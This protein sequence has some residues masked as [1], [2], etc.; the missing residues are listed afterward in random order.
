M[1]APLLFRNADAPDLA[2]NFLVAAVAAVVGVRVLLYLTGYPSV[3]GARLH[4]AHMLWG[5]LLLAIALVVLLSYIGAAA[6]AIASVVGGLGFG[7]FIDEIGKFVTRDNDYFYRPAVALMYLVF[8]LLYLAFRKLHGP[9]LTPTERVANALELMQEAVRRDMDADEWRRA[10]ALLERSGAD[11]LVTA[12]RGALADVTVAPH[13]RPGPM[14]RARLRLR[15][16]YRSLVA[17]RGFRRFT[18]LFFLLQAL[19]VLLEAIVLVPAAARLVAVA[20]VALFGAYGI[21]RLDAAG[22]RHTAI[23][24]A[25]VAATALLAV[26]GLVL[27]AGGVPALS[28]F[29]WGLLA[30]CIIPA[31][32]ALRGALR[33]RT[34]RRAAYRTFIRAVLV[35]IFVTQF[36][37]FYIAQLPAVVG[38]FGNV[39]I[40][41][42]LRYASQEEAR[43]AAPEPVPAR[44]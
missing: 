30:F 9:D 6:R 14:Q 18:S 20:G 12:L 7:L 2:D 4:I 21:A 34:S 15:A 41:T 16:A 35:Q 11:P 28:W 17:W 13:A 26:L 38:L 27:R 8:V 42:L 44:G 32:L 37:A 39:L 33:M 43:M 24:A 40:L 10:A 31:A 22:R 3:G 23:G 1:H 29:Q 36:F 25:L 5:G 19:L